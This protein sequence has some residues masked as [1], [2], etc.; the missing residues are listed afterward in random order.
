M[1]NILY[2]SPLHKFY[3]YY[4]HKRPNYNKWVED[5]L[6]SNCSNQTTN[7]MTRK[8]LT[9]NKLIK[10]VLL[11]TNRS[12]RISRQQF[13]HLVQTLLNTD[14]KDDD[15]IKVA[16]H[17][18]R[19]HYKRKKNEGCG[20]TGKFFHKRLA[21]FLLAQCPFAFVLKSI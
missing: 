15:S 7:H 14:H 10:C 19:Y 13:Q 2:I 21:M 17:S 4:S 1:I 12:N 3:K 18:L 8:M 9:D 16:F 11:L 6:H 5:I 20:E